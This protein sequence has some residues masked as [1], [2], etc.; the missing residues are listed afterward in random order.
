[1]FVGKQK[2]LNVCLPKVSFC[3]TDFWQKHFSG[4]PKWQSTCPEGIYGKMY[5]LLAS[6]VS[7]WSSRTSCSGTP[8]G[9][10][11]A[12]CTTNF[13]SGAFGSWWKWQNGFWKNL[14]LTQY[15][16]EMKWSLH[17]G[18]HFSQT[19]HAAARLE[20]QLIDLH[21]WLINYLLVIILMNFSAS[22]DIR[23]AFQGYV[24]ERN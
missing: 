14:Q 13:S 21:A 16:L 18:S 3:F 1:M 10:S 17:A 4:L 6:S 23:M 5:R 12:I 8:N 22:N 7:P 2:C 24:E 11:L 15:L 19:F 20:Y 9:L